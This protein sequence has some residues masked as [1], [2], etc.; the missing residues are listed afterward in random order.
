[1][2]V[3]SP[4]TPVGDGDVKPT[5]TGK[6]IVDFLAGRL[7]A[8]VDT[9]LNL[10]DVRDVA[11]GHLLAAERGRPGERYIL[12]NANVTLKE[13]LATLARIAGRAAPRLR[14]P[15]WVPLAIAHM[16]APIARLLGRAPR[17]PLDGVRMARSNDVLRGG[18]AVRE[19][20]LPQSPIE[21]AL[22][23]AVEWFCR[24]A[25]PGNGRAAAFE[26]RGR[27]PWRARRRRRARAGA[28]EELGQGRRLT[29]EAGREQHPPDRAALVEA[30]VEEGRQLL[31]RGVADRAQDQPGQT[32]RGRGG[33]R[34]PPT[35]DRPPP[36]DPGARAAVSDRRRC[37][38]ATVAARRGTEIR[39][40]GRAPA[41]RAAPASQRR[42]RLPRVAVLAHHPVRHQQLARRQLR[43]QGA[44]DA[45]RDHDARAHA[46]ERGGRPRSRVAVAVAGHGQSHVASPPAPAPDGAL[47][48]PAGRRST[49]IARSG[50]IS[51]GS[52]AS[53]TR[54][55]RVVRRRAA[56]D[57]AF[58]P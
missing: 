47:A 38:S 5:P 32:A 24:T 9:G 29:E 42:R 11:A 46:A 39:A 33:A 6:I 49:S 31:G 12:A 20:G 10:I 36:S 58:T 52:A 44:R 43:R 19:L 40:A 50:R 13:L 41:S 34:T 7:P 17:V 57:H 37:L 18:K 3:V 48:P 45:D 8:Y 21:P 22:R 2:V 51:S 26:H 23:R 15:H 4:S 28:A 56:R 35:P 53:T 55:D 16:E 54:V 14:L 27:A 25:T 30:A 1:M